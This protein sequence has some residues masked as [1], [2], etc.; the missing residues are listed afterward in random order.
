M[1]NKVAFFYPSEKIGGAQVLFLRAASYLAANGYIVYNID[2]GNSF[3]TSQLRNGNIAFEHIVQG[4]NR[5]NTELPEDII[6][7][8]SLSYIV[9]IERFFLKN[10]SYRFI[11]WDLHPNNLIDHTYFSFFYKKKLSKALTLGL[12]LFE[13]QRIYKLK[14]F[15]EDANEKNGLVFMCRNNYIT[16]SK[17]F[18]TKISPS[19]LPIIQDNTIPLNEIRK[20]KPIYNGVINIGWLSRLEDDK[21]SILNL[22]IKDCDKYAANNYNECRLYLHIIGEGSAIERIIKPKNFKLVFAGKLYDSQLSDYISNNVDIGFAMG[23]SVLEFGI[24]R[25]PAVLVPSS[26]LYNYYKDRESRYMWLYKADGYDVATEIYHK[27]TEL[28]VFSRIFEQLFK[29]DELGN[30][31]FKY[32]YNSHS[33]D[34][35]G[36]RLRLNIEKCNLTAKDI[37]ATKIYSFSNLEKIFHFFKKALKG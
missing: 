36:D 26:T 17:F 1:K 28:E 7:I 10:E 29:N 16:N 31:T 14:R 21:V 30:K 24:R 2:Y 5:P 13:R 33:L 15:L 34:Q 11:F 22:L 6:F 25:I 37:K 19:Y 23:T 4:E 35:I 20:P 18:K 32:V 8:V 3:I 27:K 12:K 9:E